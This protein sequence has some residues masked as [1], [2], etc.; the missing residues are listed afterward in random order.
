MNKLR[1]M[2][3]VLI[4]GAFTLLSTGAAQ[5]YPPNDVNVIITIPN[6][7]LIGGKTVH[8]KATTDVGD[9]NCH[10]TVKLDNGTAPG[11]GETL[12]GNGTSFSGSYKTKVVSH[13]EPHA[14]KATCAYDDSD[15]ATASAPISH[16]NTVTPAIYVA[17]SGST[18]LAAAQTASASATVTLLPLGG[19]DDNGALPNTGGSHLWVLVLGGA[20]LVA[21][22]GV[23][24]ATRRRSSH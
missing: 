12:T 16:S 13:I 1:L 5:A 9:L 3:A 17:G 19:G 21:G 24:V 22:G 20:L 10:W 6:A 18:L 23:I 4:A 15:L 8:F 14:L 2:A 7:T 11:V